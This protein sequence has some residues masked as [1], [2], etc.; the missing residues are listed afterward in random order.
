MGAAS[1]GLAFPQPHAAGSAGI[2]SEKLE[3]EKC[4]YR[5]SVT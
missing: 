5:A 4:N 3:G 2:G 1:V